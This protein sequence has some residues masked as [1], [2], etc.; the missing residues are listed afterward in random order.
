M[1]ERICQRVKIPNVTDTDMMME[2]T[3]VC[4]TKSVPNT[5][6]LIDDMVLGKQD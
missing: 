3:T 4:M 1:Y 5:E 2:P 6:Q